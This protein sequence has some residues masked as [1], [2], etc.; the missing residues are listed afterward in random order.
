MLLLDSYTLVRATRPMS[1]S[2]VSQCEH[3]PM[4]WLR[5]PVAQSPQTSYSSGKPATSLQPA[6]SQTSLSKH[7][8]ML[9][10]FPISKVTHRTVYRLQSLFNPRQVISFSLSC[11]V[12]PTCQW[13]IDMRMANA[14]EKKTGIWEIVNGGILA[15]LLL[16]SM[17][18]PHIWLY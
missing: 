9:A 15:V 18:W 3:V 17:L 2:L 13:Y 11:F 10:C 7:S 16:F 6:G 14:E 1:P 4:F 8:W 12:A 5:F